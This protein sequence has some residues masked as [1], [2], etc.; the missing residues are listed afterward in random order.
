[1]LQAPYFC[2][3]TD[4]LLLVPYSPR[5]CVTS[6]LRQVFKATFP[7]TA[8]GLEQLRLQQGMA[9][10][11]IKFKLWGGGQAPP[12]Y[13]TFE[14][15]RSRYLNGL[16]SFRGQLLEDSTHLILRVLQGFAGLA[17]FITEWPLFVQASDRRARVQL[18]C[19]FDE[20]LPS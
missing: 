12:I 8:F 20:D 9:F 10:R 13:R 11:I 14:L 7:A 4:G 1:M 15:L 2:F 17:L 5:G 3:R 16:S 19:V 6:C 18:G